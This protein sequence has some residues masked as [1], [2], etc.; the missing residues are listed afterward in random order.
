M[1]LRDCKGSG[2]PTTYLFQRSIKSIAGNNGQPFGKIENQAHPS[3]PDS[4]LHPVSFICFATGNASQRNRLTSK[5]PAATATMVATSPGI[6]NEWF[7][8]YFPI[9]VVPVRSKLIAATTVG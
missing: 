7:S 9:R 1:G 2:F 3:I 4:T 6:I 8:T 5:I